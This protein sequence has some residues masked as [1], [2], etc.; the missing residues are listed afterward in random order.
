MREYCPYLWSGSAKGLRCP[1]CDCQHGPE[2]RFVGARVS[3][4]EYL[5]EHGWR[6]TA[7]GWAMEGGFGKPLATDEAYQIQTVLENLDR[8]DGQHVLCHGCESDTSEAG[9]I[10]CRTCNMHGHRDDGE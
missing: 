7:R 8:L 3:R 9:S 5:R 1:N 4:E 2:P 6:E 10:F